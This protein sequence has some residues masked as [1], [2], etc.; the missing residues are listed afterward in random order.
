MI[1]CIIHNYVLGHFLLQIKNIQKGIG[2]TLARIS[3]ETKSEPYSTVLANFSRS[4]SSSQ[5]N[6]IIFAMLNR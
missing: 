2:Y 3:G 4:K 5:S 1:K 6:H